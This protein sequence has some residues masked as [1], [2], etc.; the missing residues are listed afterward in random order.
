MYYHHFIQFFTSLRHVV[1]YGNFQLL[2]IGFMVSPAGRAINRCTLIKICIKKRYTNQPRIT[3]KSK[4]ECVDIIKD[5]YPANP[6]KP[7]RFLRLVSDQ[8]VQRNAIV[9]SVRTCS[10]GCTDHSCCR[11]AVVA[12]LQPLQA[13]SVGGAD[14]LSSSH[15][16]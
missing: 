5:F 1:K 15:G 3:E 11:P 6:L 10:P 12:V 7:G 14:A 4:S 9:V 13:S 2:T 8:C 16:V